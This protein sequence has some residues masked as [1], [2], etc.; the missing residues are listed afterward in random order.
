MERLRVLAANV[1]KQR[2]AMRQLLLPPPADHGQ[3]VR[4]SRGYM[5]GKISKEGQVWKRKMS[6]CRSRAA[7]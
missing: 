6:C 5:P 3:A 1:T 2:R 7:V 4:Q